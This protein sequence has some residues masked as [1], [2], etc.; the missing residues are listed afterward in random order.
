MAG[1]KLED[2]R[3]FGYYYQIQN[4]A[5]L[6]LDFGTQIFVKMLNGRTITLE[7]DPSDTVGD[8]KAKI[9]DQQRIIFDG[10]RL[11]DQRKLGS[12]KVQNHSTLHLDLCPCDGMQIAVKTLPRSKDIRY[13]VQFTDKVGDLKAKIQDQQRLCTLTVPCRSL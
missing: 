4:D 1:N 5:T 9:Q 13:K 10:S 8:V 12:Y 3:T 7:V 6:H 11:D 2:D